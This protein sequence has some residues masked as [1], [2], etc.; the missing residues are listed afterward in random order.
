MRFQ[1]A[2]VEAQNL[3]GIAK[4]TDTVFNKRSNSKD[5]LVGTGLQVP[6]K[7]NWSKSENERSHIVGK[8]KNKKNQVVDNYLIPDLQQGHRKQNE[9]TVYTTE[10]AYASKTVSSSLT[11]IFTRK[12]MDNFPFY[13]PRI[14][15]DFNSYKEK[16][17]MLQTDEELNSFSCN[18][19]DM[20]ARD[21]FAYS[22]VKIRSSVP[23]DVPIPLDQGMMNGKGP[24]EGLHLSLN[25]YMSE[26]GYNKKCIH[27]IENRLPFSLPFQESTSRVPQFN[28]IDSETN[29]FGGPSIPSRHTTNTISGKGVHCKVSC[30]KNLQRI[31]SMIS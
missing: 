25:S 27:Q 2:G 20:L 8:K 14:E 4:T 16:G 29:V 17:K 9:D 26:H 18:R 11:P 24:E 5:V 3:E 7:G 15:N 31:L 30:R 23:S 12:G 21:S 22:G 13:T 6:E 1:R 19:N 10:K 28:R